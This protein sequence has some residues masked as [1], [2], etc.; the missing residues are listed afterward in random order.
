MWYE[1][2]SNFKFSSIHFHFHDNHYH[3]VIRLLHFLMF[4]VYNLH[5][6]FFPYLSL[7]FLGFLSSLLSFCVF[8]SP[9]SFL[10]ITFPQHSSISSLYPPLLRLLFFSDKHIFLISPPFHH[11]H[12]LA[13]NFTSFIYENFFPTFSCHFS[14]TKRLSKLH[15]RGEFNK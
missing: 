10:V 11:S 13:A 12:I 3:S 14:E 9:P 4:L 1:S 8:C 15:T 2:L 6:S 5:T 7:I